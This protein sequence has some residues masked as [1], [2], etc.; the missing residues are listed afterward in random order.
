MRKTPLLIAL[1]LVLT[2]AG[3]GL[4]QAQ[5]PE[6][7]DNLKQIVSALDGAVV[8]VRDGGSKEASATSLVQTA[9]SVYDG[10]F[11]SRM[12]N[13]DNQLDSKIVNA[14]AEMGTNPTE[15]G[16]F[17]LRADVMAA[18]AQLGVTI[19]P[20]YTY[21]LFVVLGVSVAVSFLVTLLSKKMVN[22]QFV[23]ESK[24]KISEFMKEYRDATRRQDRKRMHKME[25]KR[26]EIQRLQ[27]QVM[28]QQMKPTLFYIV[29]LLLL[30]SVLGATFSG[31]VVA[32]LPFGIDLPFFGSLVAFG[33]GWWYFL[34]FMAFS[35][36][37][38]AI[39]IREDVKPTPP[40]GP[41]PVPVAGA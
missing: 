23:G 12:E 30:W 28:T 10:S 15:S 33:F 13:T 39:M 40:A 24:A 17:S 26:A 22:W 5:T 8:A 19:S 36:I 20:V 7:H 4:V 3:A 41:A 31:W 37:F 38:R 32:W 27:G 29:P 35:F 11:K 18:A 25:A 2:L 21:S 6:D 14:F 1:A 9:N 16:I 34:S